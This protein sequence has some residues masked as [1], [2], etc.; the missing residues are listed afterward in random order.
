V[1]VGYIST[2]AGYVD[3]YRVIANIFAPNGAYIA[4]WTE[5]KKYTDWLVLICAVVLQMQNPNNA[6]G[7]MIV[8]GESGT[9]L[10][11]MSGNKLGS[12]KKK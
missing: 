7:V 4:N 10:T 11:S 5:R 9:A 12:S 8:D 2:A 6:S 3:K 1:T